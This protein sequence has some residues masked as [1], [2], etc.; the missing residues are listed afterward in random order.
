MGRTLR[1]VVLLLST[2]FAAYNC[3]GGP[4]KPRL[5]MFVGIDIS[6]SFMQ[7]GYY[8][9]SIDFLAHYLYAHLNGLG[10]LE[11]PNVLFVSS[12]GGATANEPKTFFPKQTFEDKSVQEIAAKLREIFPEGVQNPFTDYNAFFEQIAL[13]IRNRKLVLRPISIVMI[14]DGR[15]DVKRAGKTD[16]RSIKFKPLESL[17]RNI[18]VRLLYTTAEVGNKWQTRV[19]RSRVKVWTQDAE[20]MVSWKDPTMLIAEKPLK[21]QASFLRWV[22]ENVDYGVAS[23]RVD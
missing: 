3:G 18:T 5:S 7:S 9:D 2:I 10:G 17:S 23:R 14:S 15:P 20:V 4:D 12:I 8:D 16:F 19:P 22:K 21:E 1:T 6:G 11:V 13:T